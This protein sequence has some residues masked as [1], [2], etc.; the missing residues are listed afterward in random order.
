MFEVRFEVRAEYPCR[1]G[2]IDLIAATHARYGPVMVDIVDGWRVL[3]WRFR[4]FCTAVRVRW[5]LECRYPIE[6][7]TF[8]EL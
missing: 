1:M 3:V 4:D 2:N 6:R 5:R 7:V 8:R